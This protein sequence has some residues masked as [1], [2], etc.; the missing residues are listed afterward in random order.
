MPFHTSARQ[1]RCP[2]DVTQGCHFLIGFR[3][4]LQQLYVI[5]WAWVSGQTSGSCHKPCA[6]PSISSCSWIRSNGRAK[7]SQPG[8]VRLKANHTAR[9]VSAGAHA[10]VPARRVCVAGEYFITSM[11]GKG[12]FKQTRMYVCLVGRCLSITGAF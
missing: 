8:Q 11:F 4:Q 2:R 3:N 10:S 1:N 12:S 7:G 9:R 6:E 5:S